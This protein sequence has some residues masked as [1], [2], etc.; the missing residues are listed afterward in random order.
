MSMNE[1]KEQ[2][3]S[4]AAVDSSGQTV[5][6]MRAPPY[7]GDMTAWQLYSTS[8]LTSFTPALNTRTHKHTQAY[9]EISS[10]DY[11]VVR[12]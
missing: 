9:T 11:A 12:R 7:G 8:A 4:R 10:T 2:L 1:E 5:W 6:L 3:V